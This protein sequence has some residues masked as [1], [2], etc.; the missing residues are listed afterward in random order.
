MGR[1]RI[2]ICAALFACICAP[3]EAQ[4]VLSADGRLYEI[5]ADGSDRRPFAAPATVGSGDFEPE[6]SPDGAQLAVV[7]DRNPRDFDAPTQIDLL[8]AD[9]STRQEF[10]PDERNVFVSSPRWSPDGE[11]LAFARAT[12]RGDRYTT[13]IVVRE[14]DGSEVVVV[15]QRLDRRLT[16]VAA[17]EWSPDGGG[18]LYSEFRI[19][20]RFYFQA[21]IRSAP[22][23]GGPTRP[24]IRRAHSPAFS[25]DGTRIAFISIAD[26]NGETCGSDECA[27]NG[28]LYV[29][30]ADG[31]NPTRLTNSQGDDAAP[32][33]APDG[34]RIA[35]N[36]NRNFPEAEAAHELYSVEPD[37][38]CLT[39]LTNGTATSAGPAWRPGTTTTDPGGC[40]ATARP[41]LI[42]VDLTPARRAES[43]TG[44]WLGLTHRGLLLSEVDRAPLYFGY[45]DCARYRPR[46]C[47]PGVQL[48][49]SSVC[50]RDAAV[51]FLA[52][53]VDR[54]RGAMVQDYYGGEGGL[55]VITGTTEVHIPDGQVRR[56]LRA[57]RPFPRES[58][59]ERLRAPRIPA[60]LVREIARAERL[61]DR[62]GSVA[63]VARRMH[64]RRETV[65]NRLA[66]AE[67]LE[68]YGHRV[69]TTHCAR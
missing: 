31:T 26:R 15:R 60:E 48:I 9:G 53:R 62:L 37:G 43:T 61:H 34:S 47:P 55:T 7:R 5:D 69:R 64:L 29:A 2:A 6:W 14:L 19:G 68:R 36:S 39:W 65:R 4:I 52:G 25:P 35:F 22:L 27:Y 50:S 3:A 10:T 11:R 42:E 40:G 49:V 30:D 13:E 63:A 23:A 67:A 32:A 54:R 66:N 1:R 33:W 51:E 58:A 18:V 56:A 17:P 16:S 21:S 41:P 12:T 28:E 8:S 44:L 57:L 59:V 20:R 46:D 45:Y 24:L 38:D